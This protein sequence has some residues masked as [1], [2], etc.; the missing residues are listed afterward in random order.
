[1][2][3]KRRLSALRGAKN[4]LNTDEG[5]LEFGLQRRFAQAIE[6]ESIPFRP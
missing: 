5:C 4:T 3:S 1:M 2:E 6:E